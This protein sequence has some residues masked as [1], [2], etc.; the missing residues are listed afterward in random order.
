MAL[1]VNADITALLE[2]LTTGDEQRV[3]CET[4]QL[5]GPEQVPPA[6]LAARV[7][8]PAAWG[9]GDG[10]PLSVLSVAGRIAEWMR[11]IPI[12]PEPGSEARRLLAPALP[13][14]QGFLAV[15]DRVRKGLPEPHPALPDP[16]LPADVAQE[17][18]SLAALRKS[19]AQRDAK[20]T[21]GILMGYYATGTDYR[22]MLTA[23]YA[24][25]DVRY[26]EA[27]RPFTYAVAGSRV[28]DMANWGDRVPAYVYWVTPLLVDSAPDTPAAEAAR[29]YAAASEHD[30][31][32]LRTRLSIPKEEAAG[33]AFQQA[34]LSGDAQAACDAVL[35]ALRAGATPIG[36]AAGIA[37]AAADRVNAVPEGDR[38]ELL[39]TAQ[40]LR[41]AHSVHVAM[42][43]TQNPEVWPLLYTAACAVNAIRVTAPANA[44]ERSAPVSTPVGGL[45]AASMLRTIEKQIDEGDT[46]GALS[47]T[48]RYLQMGHQSRALAGIIGSVAA[49][50][51]AVSSDP[52]SLQILPVV[53]AAA[54]EYLT[55]PKALEAGGQNPMLNAAIRLA[56]ELRGEHRVADQVR[57]A[58]SIML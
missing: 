19:I 46:A 27:G 56:A 55:L 38:E 5:L 44:V 12:G 45:I 10:D 15:A 7:G 6:K 47:T 13:L 33:P 53:A 11:A 14:V 43:Q 21:A 36:V 2:A 16:I 31:R 50:R 30:L 49:T 1:M 41:Y 25:L 4:L 54:E 34:L 40:V 20:T 39:R 22:E 48:R 37:L 29:A 8:I 9:N 52:Q 18:G 51:D 35:Q 57:E 58:I 17:G 26:P 3:I 42:L 24:A 23:V 32:W 28:L